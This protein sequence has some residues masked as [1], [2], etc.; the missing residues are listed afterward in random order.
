MTTELQ[1]IIKRLKESIEK[2][3]LSYVELEKRTG[4]AKSSIQR[5][6]SGT[7]KKVPIDA[8]QAIARAVGVSDKYIMGWSDNITEEKKPLPNNADLNTVIFFFD[9]VIALVVQLQKFP[10]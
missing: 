8:I 6:A 1:E 5:Y 10:R 3:G 4:I 9:K 7:T 2:S